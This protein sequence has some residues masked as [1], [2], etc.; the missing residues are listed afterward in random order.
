MYVEWFIGDDDDD[1]NDDND[2]III[3]DDKFHYRTHCK[4][5]NNDAQRQLLLL[6]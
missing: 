5:C 4:P 3:Y 6:L 2:E 1:D